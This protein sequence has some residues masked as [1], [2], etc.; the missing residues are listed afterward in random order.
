MDKVINAILEAKP[1]DEIKFDWHSTNTAA[2]I[3]FDTLK[4]YYLK[5]EKE[6]TEYFS[7]ARKKGKAVGLAFCYGGT[8]FMVKRAY[9]DLSDKE[10]QT[11]EKNFFSNLPVFKRYLDKLLKTAESTL[12]VKTFA[13]RHI[14]VTGLESDQWFIR[15]EAKNGVYNYPIQGGGGE[16]I[17]L[18]L[19]DASKW[20]EDN[21]MYALQGNLICDN[22]ATRVVAISEKDIE[23]VDAESGQKLEGILEQCING[24]TLILVTNESYTEVLSEFDR[25]VKINMS[26]LSQYNAKIIF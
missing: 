21:R 12:Y 8:W 4:E 6:G 18:I 13:G 20:I 9:P 1:S 16:L 25:S 7:K 10:A 19:I 17:R 24:N 15:N 3:G 11:I 22:Y 26:V 2:Q 14:P 23:R 5:D